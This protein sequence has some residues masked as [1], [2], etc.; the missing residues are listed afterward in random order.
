M[1]YTSKDLS[2][3]EVIK[4][5]LV[6]TFYFVTFKIILGIFSDYRTTNKCKLRLKFKQF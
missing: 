4:H 6:R 5:E 1:D 3:F 2:E